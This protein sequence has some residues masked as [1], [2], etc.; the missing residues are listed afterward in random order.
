MAEQVDWT[1]AIRAIVE[2]MVA[3]DITEL[4]MRRG[5]LRLRLRRDPRAA[6]ARSLKV[7]GEAPEAASPQTLHRVLAPLTGV[8]YAAPNPSSSPYVA[9][10]DWVE[11]DSVVGLIETMKVFN[12]VAAECRGRVM[13]ILVKH[14]RL[15]H[16]GEPILLVDTEAIPDGTNGVTP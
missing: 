14:G 10:G 4:E 2:H 13:E 15:I 6:A 3:A 11:P 8:Y 5:E 7:I 1:A 9:I 12:Q 16:A